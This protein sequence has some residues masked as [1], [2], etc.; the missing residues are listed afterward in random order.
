M[1]RYIT[2][3]EKRLTNYEEREKQ[4]IKALQT[5][6]LP[7][8]LERLVG[9]T[10]KVPDLPSSLDTGNNGASDSKSKDK[11]LSE[12]DIQ[13]GVSEEPDS[14]SKGGKGENHTHSK[15]DTE[16]SEQVSKGDDGSTKDPNTQSGEETADTGSKADTGGR[17]N[18]DAQKYKKRNQE[19]KTLLKDVYEE[20]KGKNKQISDLT[21][22]VN[23]LKSSTKDISE[24]NIQLL[25]DNYRRAMEENADLRER[26]NDLDEEVVHLK[27]KLEDKQ[28]ETILHNVADELEAYTSQYAETRQEEEKVRSVLMQEQVHDY[29]EQARNSLLKLEDFERVKEAC[30]EHERNI[31]RQGWSGEVFPTD[32]PQW[33]D[34]EL[35]TWKHKDEVQLPNGAWYWLNE[36]SVDK[37][38]DVDE[39]GWQYGETFEDLQERRHNRSV[40]RGLKSAEDTVRRRKWIRTRVKI[41]LLTSSSKIGRKYTQ[42]C[43]PEVK[44]VLTEACKT[45]LGLARRLEAQDNILAAVTVELRKRQETIRQYETRVSSLLQKMADAETSGDVNRLGVS[46]AAPIKIIRGQ[47][48]SQ[49]N[50]KA[51]ASPSDT[52][53]FFPS[54]LSDSLT[55]SS[56][57]QRIKKRFSPLKQDDK[58]KEM[59]KKFCYAAQ[60]GNVDLLKEML[61]K[62]EVSTSDADSEGRSAVLFAARGGKIDSLEAL[63]F[64]GADFSQIDKSGRNALHY[65]TRQGCMDATVW[66][67]SQGFSVHTT[68]GH[69]LTPLHQAALGKHSLLCELLLGKGADWTSTD[70]VS[71]F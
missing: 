26:L 3:L 27:D 9:E 13:V 15:K 16:T 45:I 58:K 60:E 21:E 34:E 47:G 59:V 8:N 29:L 35:S 30:F 38:G 46:S 63:N 33:A 12:D 40:P 48:G 65:A 24:E 71:A 70:T 10:I 11:I 39:N 31:P 50:L 5:G 61:R 19:L 1:K 62:G 41:G 17:S 42:E 20:L 23:R 7:E 53:S 32:P 49:R 52:N 57:L 36:W 56:F 66:L 51:I 28:D 22:E 2:V 25:R 14:A 64:A 67:L 6:D 44:E 54:D 4:W 68:D 55:P 37:D 43:P 18:G 69:A